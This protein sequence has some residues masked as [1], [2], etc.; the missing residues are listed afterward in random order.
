MRVRWKPCCTLSSMTELREEWLRGQ[1]MGSALVNGAGQGKFDRPCAPA[2]ASDSA[3]SSRS[4]SFARR[5]AGEVGLGFA[6]LSAVGRWAGNRHQ[7]S[8]INVRRRGIA[9]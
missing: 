7:L 1:G 3:C 2:L 5:C 9:G 4:I 6:K 8:V